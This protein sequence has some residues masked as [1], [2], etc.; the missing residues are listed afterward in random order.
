MVPW[1]LMQPQRDLRA[2]A[3][4]AADAQF[5][6]QSSDAFSDM[7]QAKSCFGTFASI[8]DKAFALVAYR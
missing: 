2:L 4:L 5:A 3:W 6:T 1:L 7:E 8:D